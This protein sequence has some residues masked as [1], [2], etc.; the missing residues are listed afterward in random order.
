MTVMTFLDTHAPIRVGVVGTGFVSRHFVLS[1]DR[2]R[3]AVA[4]KVLTRRL[5]EDCA[6]Y[7]RPDLLTNSLDE[8][9]ESCDVLLECTGDPI[10]ATEVIARALRAGRPVVTMNAEF[11]I[12]AGSWFV[13]R[14]L[15]SEAA[16]DQ[17]G[18]QAE[19]AEEAAALGFEPVVYGNLKGFLNRDPSPEDMAFWAAKQG[20]SLPMVTSF[21]D[22]TKVHVEQALVANGLG[23]GIAADGLL[24]PE[25]DD[26]QAAGVRLAEAAESAGGPI[27]DYVLSRK[28]PHG[29]FL[30]AKHDGRQAAALE[31]LRLG[32]G[33]YYVLLKNNIFVHL[34]ILKTIRRVV[35]ERRPLL[36]NSPNPTISVAAVAK[37]DLRP[38]D[39]LP[40]GIGSFDIRG[41][42][43]R[44]AGH[45][46]HLPIGLLYGGVVRRPVRRGDVLA[47]DDVDLPDSL[48]LTAWTE[49]EQ[50]ALGT[51]LQ[52]AGAAE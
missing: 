15:L 42:A 9:L 45:A 50:R 5:R 36:D 19:L 35:R 39:A 3:D 2:H 14:G 49:V 52:Q 41:E 10:H 20:I 24:S 33:P 7:P 40:Y 48:A 8:V 46:G 34:E 12:T 37:R 32:K 11:H 30:V 17:P 16:G 38:G 18:C 29:V 44:I 22:G 13:G 28:L 31:Y 4:V 43:V 21:T 1:L 6:D 25:N 27:A 26:L 51:P 23:A 47:L